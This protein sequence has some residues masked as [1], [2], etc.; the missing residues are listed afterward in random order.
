MATE[1]ET[2]TISNADSYK[3]H[4]EYLRARWIQLRVGK[5]LEMAVKPDVIAQKE[6]VFVCRFVDRMLSLSLNRAGTD[7]YYQEALDDINLMRH[8]LS[9]VNKDG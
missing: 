9:E 2:P 7:G 6:A 1:M 3:A 5:A 4:N 8:N